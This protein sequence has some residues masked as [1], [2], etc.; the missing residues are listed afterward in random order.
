MST[1]NLVLER[2]VALKTR[3]AK[4]EIM[5]Q[6]ANVVITTDEKIYLSVK[7]KK[8]YRMEHSDTR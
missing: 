4:Y 2:H 3:R 7:K 1:G 5:A 8:K 6:E